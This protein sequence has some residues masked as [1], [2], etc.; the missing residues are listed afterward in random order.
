M[1][2]REKTFTT[3]SFIR[4]E[5]AMRERGRRHEVDPSVSHEV[6]NFNLVLP[7]LSSSSLPKMQSKKSP[8]TVVG[9]LCEEDM[10]GVLIMGL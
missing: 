1:A 3:A 4:N 10:S 6:C 2:V 7:L 5:G 9:F 8:E